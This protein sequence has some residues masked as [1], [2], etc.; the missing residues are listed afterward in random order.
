[1]CMSFCG[2]PISNIRHSSENDVLSE[3]L[4][5]INFIQLIP[6]YNLFR[7]RSQP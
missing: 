3:N 7:A 5:I 4:P 1:M 6:S 2:L